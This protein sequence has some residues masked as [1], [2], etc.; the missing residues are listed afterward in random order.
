MKD[1]KEEENLKEKKLIRKKD[2]L[3]N[4]KDQYTK[5]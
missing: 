2:I 3:Q 1:Q 5:W 4:I